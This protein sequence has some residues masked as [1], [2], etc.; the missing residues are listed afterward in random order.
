LGDALIRR[1][2][3]AASW[4]EFLTPAIIASIIRHDVADH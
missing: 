4:C 3:I 1:S 2:A